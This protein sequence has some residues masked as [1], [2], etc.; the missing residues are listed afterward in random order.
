MIPAVGA[1]GSRL[2]R[3]PRLKREPKVGVRKRR[4]SFLS[5]SSPLHPKM[6]DIREAND[7]EGHGVG[8]LD[9]APYLG[10]GGVVNPY[11][12]GIPRLGGGE[13]SLEEPSGAHQLAGLQG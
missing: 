11:A 9:R 8:N 13:G 5:S 6:T 2:T 12:G 1:R 7:S 3:T 10:R 4:L